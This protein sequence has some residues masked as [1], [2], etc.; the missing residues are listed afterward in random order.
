M[1]SSKR[2][3]KKPTEGQSPL[4][5]LSKFVKIKSKAWEKKI[6]QNQEGARI[7]HCKIG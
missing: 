2:K 1:S 5:S 7:Y 4:K 3:I 6:P